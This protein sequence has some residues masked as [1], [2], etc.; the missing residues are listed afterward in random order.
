MSVRWGLRF[1]ATVDSERPSPRAGHGCRAGA[2]LLECEAKRS[3]NGS[4]HVLQSCIGLSQYF[5]C[6]FMNTRQ[7]DVSLRGARES[8]LSVRASHSSVLTTARCVPPDSETRAKSSSPV[9]HRSYHLLS[10]SIHQPNTT[11]PPEPS[12]STDGMVPWTTNPPRRTISIHRRHRLDPPAQQSQS[13]SRP[14]LN[15]PPVQSTHRTLLAQSTGRT[16][17]LEEQISIAPQRGGQRR[18]QCAGRV[19]RPQKVEPEGGG[20]APPT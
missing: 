7:D 18:L 16:N 9:W 12:Q 2:T 19:C 10:F 5:T 6:I 20:G 14:A 17:P 4:V 13:A 3:D 8:A 1:V 15:P 11:N